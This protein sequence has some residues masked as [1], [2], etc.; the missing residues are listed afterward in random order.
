MDRQ[1][2]A[3]TYRNGTAATAV[4]AARAQDKRSTV[5]GPN[6][7]KLSAQALVGVSFQG[8]PG[9]AERPA[10]ERA[11]DRLHEVGSHINRDSGTLTPNA[12]TASVA[13]EVPLP[14]WLARTQLEEH[15]R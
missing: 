11:G 4:S 12:L 13:S 14:P 1:H 6:A 9:V 15:K 3:G 8:R 5:R 2:H 7:D 10:P